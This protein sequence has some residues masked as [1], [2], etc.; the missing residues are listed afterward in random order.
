LDSFIYDRFDNDINRR[1]NKAYN[2][3]DHIGFQGAAVPNFDP[4]FERMKEV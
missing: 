3:K 4:E 1:A 2:L